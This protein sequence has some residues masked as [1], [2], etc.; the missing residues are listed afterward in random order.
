MNPGTFWDVS[1]TPFYKNI[2]A[3]GAEQKGKNH[4]TGSLKIINPPAT[5][6]PTQKH[7]QKSQSNKSAISFI[8][9]E[10]R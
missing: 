2:R 7:R 6:T 8:C 1:G 4:G 3:N 9:F 10:S 5:S